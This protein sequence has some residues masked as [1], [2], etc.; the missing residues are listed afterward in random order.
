MRQQGVTQAV[1]QFHLLAP[2][3]LIT[4]A[5]AGVISGRS[6]ASIYRHFK[7]GSLTP[8]KIGHSTRIRVGE[9]RR[10]IGVA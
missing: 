9:L 10:L 2:S 4:L 6:R 3:V 8:I 5:E 7:D 1:Q